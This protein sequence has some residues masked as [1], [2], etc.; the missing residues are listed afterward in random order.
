M[1][2]TGGVNNWSCLSVSCYGGWSGFGAI[3]GITPFIAPYLNL[4]AIVDPSD[5][6]ARGYGGYLYSND[7]AGGPGQDGLFVEGAYLDW[8]LEPPYTVGM[9]SPGRVYSSN[10]QYVQCL[11]QLTQ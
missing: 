2:S 3:G 11:M 4:G 10:S 7:W 8:L 6:G 5:G 1:P 9:C